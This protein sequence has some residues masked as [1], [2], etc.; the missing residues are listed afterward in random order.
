MTSLVQAIQTVV[1]QP[2][3]E[4]LV[5]LQGALLA[6]GREGEAL[7]DAL[8]VAGHFYRFL[9]ELQSKVTARQYSEFASLL[10]IG[11]VGAV[12][13]EN[14]SD[15]DGPDFWRRLFLGGLG[16][17]LMV[18][19]SRQYVK[20]WEA[21][22]SVVFACATWCLQDLLWRVSSWLQPGMPGEE[23]WRAIQ[24]LLAPARDKELSGSAKAVL[25]G[26]VFQVLLL[27]YLARL[28]PTL[29]DER[30]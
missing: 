4:G 18:A 27:T 11:A 14:L 8:E 17:T 10:D 15:W 9:C 28:S 5:A 3:P 7:S 24:T 2:T 29:E 19:A 13:V 25:L 16:E 30:A 22:T 6:S 21:E 12:A 23:R 20:A 26:R 1:T